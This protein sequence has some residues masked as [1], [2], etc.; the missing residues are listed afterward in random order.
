MV[1]TL[2]ILNSQFNIEMKALFLFFLIGLAMFSSGQTFNKRLTF[3]EAINSEGRNCFQT[4]DAYIFFSAY[5]DSMSNIRGGNIRV[6]ENGDILS[7]STI[8]SDS[9]QLYLGYYGNFDHFEGG[10]V[11]CG[12]Y[13][14]TPTSI[15]QG[16]IIRFDEHGD[17][18]WTKIYDAPI[19]EEV[20]LYKALKVWDGIVACGSYFPV[21]GTAT[22]AL[23]LKFDNE[24][25][26]L[27]RKNYLY[28]QQADVSLNLVSAVATP[29]GGY[30][31]GGV[32][33][34]DNW[35]HMVIKTDSLGNQIWRK[36]EGDGYDNLFAMVCNTADGNYI[37]GGMDQNAY[38]YHARSQITKIN[39]NGIFAWTKFFG[40]EGP[41]CWVYA[42]KQMPDGG[43]VFCGADRSS[44]SLYGYI[45][46]I[47]AEGNEMWYRKYQQMEDVWV[48]A[49][50]VVH[51]TDNGFLLTGLIETTSD[52]SSGIWALKLDSMGCLIPGCEVGII[53]ADK[54]AAMRI[55][56]NPADE[57]INVFVESKNLHN[58]EMILYDLQG[59]EIYCTT[60][61]ESGN[62]WMMNSATLPTGIYLLN[63][64]LDG[65][66][67][68]SEKVV[69]RH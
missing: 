10:F 49:S 5:L 60:I 48:W 27:W 30:I 41:D 56:P 18:L 59:K 8:H 51:T 4:S 22:S 37:F 57:F 33:I 11:S 43:F 54:L 53:E 21:G 64:S 67:V 50:D 12:N 9:V 2:E 20:Y 7:Q 63:L 68:A 39:A 3:S 15:V 31:L 6:D 66:V 44:W 28:T 16:E 23:L 13:Y 55:Y 42:I 34:G 19:G 52:L 1:S 46:R 45:C 38:Q 65:E 40:E 14:A 32:K 62:T 61:R 47:D 24:G 69:I 29:D 26:F 25:N 17:T 36:Y 58:C 35:D